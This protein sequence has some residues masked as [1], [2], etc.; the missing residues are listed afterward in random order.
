MPMTIQLAGL[1]SPSTN[2]D[3]IEAYT[4][5]SVTSDIFQASVSYINW[6]LV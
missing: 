5:Y 6:K 1:N 3:L 2:A 4:W